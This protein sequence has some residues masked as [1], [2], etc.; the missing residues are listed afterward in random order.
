MYVM[1]GSSEMSADFQGICS[2]ISQK[3][4]LIFVV[5]NFWN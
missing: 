1:T 2:G 3:T 4:E 5:N